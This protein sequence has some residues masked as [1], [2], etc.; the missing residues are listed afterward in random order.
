MSPP[1]CDMVLVHDDDLVQLDRIYGSTVSIN[2]MQYTILLI[3]SHLAT[4]CSPTGRGIRQHP[5]SQANAPHH[6]DRWVLLLLVLQR[7]MS[8]REGAH[9]EDLSSARNGAS[10]GTQPACVATLSNVFEKQCKLHDLSRLPLDYIA[11]HS[12]S[13]IR[14]LCISDSPY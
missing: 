12:G 6:S 13:V 5:G 1:N 10:V 8:H 11:A 3:I 7:C 2:T 14:I 9:P 4:Q